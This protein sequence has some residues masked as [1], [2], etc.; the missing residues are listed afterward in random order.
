MMKPEE[1]AKRARALPKQYR[2]DVTTRDIVMASYV[3]LLA[4]ALERACELLGE[5][6]Q[7]CPSPLP[8]MQ[9]KDTVL[10][11]CSGCGSYRIAKAFGGF[12][13]KP[14][15][16]AEAARDFLASDVEASDGEKR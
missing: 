6:E 13:H 10:R 5:W 9:D 14:D 8:T 16:S 2:H 11:Y 1:L 12:T 15:C 4:A 3:P 7:R